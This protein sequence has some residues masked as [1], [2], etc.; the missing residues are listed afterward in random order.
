MLHL[1]ATPSL[2]LLGN[3]YQ[4][5]VVNCNDLLVPLGEKL[6]IE[7]HPR[8]VLALSLLHLDSCL[9]HLFDHVFCK[10]NHVIT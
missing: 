5:V 3:P 9:S 10:I 1:V 6:I 7:S 4:Q 2:D 8:H